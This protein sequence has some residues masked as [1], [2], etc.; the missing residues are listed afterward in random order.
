MTTPANNLHN[1]RETILVSAEEVFAQYSFA[2]ASIRLITKRSG[3]NSSMISYYFG[4]KEGLYH[5]IFKLRLK[6]FVEEI[7]QFEGLDLGPVEK[8]TAYLA[9]Y[10]N[11]VA[12]NQNFHRLLSNE[13]VAVQHPSIIAGVSD[14]RNRLYDFLLKMIENGIDKG[15]F[16]KID[17]EVFVLNILALVRS[18]FIDYLALR[19]HSNKPPHED[20]VRRI[21]DHIMSMLTLED[22]NQFVRK[23]HV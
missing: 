1:K 18:V 11:R 19:I 5:S 21:M 14:A 6:E 7:N 17:G 22:H 10:I 2:G 13:L 16:R 23:N 4:S 12:S 3:V 8:V 9:A 20:F 15:C